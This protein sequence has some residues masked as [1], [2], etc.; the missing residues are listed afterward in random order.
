MRICVGMNPTWLRCSI[1]WRCHLLISCATYENDGV[2][3]RT[4][5]T[6][7]SSSRVRFYF[8]LIFFW[9]MDCV[10][11]RSSKFAICSAWIVRVS[12]LEWKD[13]NSFCVSFSSLSHVDSWSEM[14]TKTQVIRVFWIYVCMEKNVSILVN[15]KSSFCHVPCMWSQAWIIIKALKPKRN[16]GHS[17]SCIKFLDASGCIYLFVWIL[18]DWDAQSGEDP[19]FDCAT[20]ENDGVLERICQFSFFLKG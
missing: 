12:V 19:S 4:C 18:H 17:G 3:E 1:W 5:Y 16:L 6:Q 15:L 20:C 10:L 8:K 13:G 7:F 14:H 11:L 2:P 9:I